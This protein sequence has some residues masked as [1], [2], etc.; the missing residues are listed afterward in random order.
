MSTLDQVGIFV[1]LLCFAAVAVLLLRRGKSPP[2]RLAQTSC[3]H[4]AAMY[5]E[6]IFVSIVT[7]HYRWTLARGHNRASLR[8]P[9]ATHLVTCPQ[10]L[11]EFEFK[12]DGTLF[13][14]PQQ[15]ILSCVRTGRSRNFHEPVRRPKVTLAV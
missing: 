1:A 6:D 9:A 14:Y 4:C 12:S 7:I 8:L 11:A 2:A 10:C 13:E 3:P 15:G 5:G